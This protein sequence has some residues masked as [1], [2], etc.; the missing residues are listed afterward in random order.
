M[1]KFKPFIRQRVRV[2][3]EQKNGRPVSDTNNSHILSARSCI[4]L[5][6]GQRLSDEG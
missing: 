3:V 1:E 5:E 4:E 2:A 6:Y